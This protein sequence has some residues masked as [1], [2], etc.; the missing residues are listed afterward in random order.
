MDR[1]MIKL[2]RS[3][4]GTNIPDEPITEPIFTGD[5]YTKLIT[6]HDVVTGEQYNYRF[7]VYVPGGDSITGDQ[8]TVRAPSLYGPGNQDRPDYGND[9]LWWLPQTHTGLLPTK[10]DL[11]TISGA[12]EE[13][14]LG[15]DDTWHKV[16]VG[17]EIYFIPHKGYIRITNKD[18]LWQY[19]AGN[20]LVLNKD[21]Y[22]YTF[23]QYLDQNVSCVVLDPW[24]RKSNAY[25][26]DY[27]KDNMVAAVAKLDNVSTESVLVLYGKQSTDGA[28][29]KVTGPGTGYTRAATFYLVSSKPMDTNWYWKPI[30]KFI[31]RNDGAV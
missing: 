5:G 14:F 23:E 20:N 27:P 7:V 24:L 4:Y 29:I 17:G 15:W 6:D 31:P 3:D 22:S 1:T 26:P 13:D 19:Y 21:G 25:N 28:V 30:I 18:K 16:S 12:T 2:Y 9:S 8:F 10:A 11:M